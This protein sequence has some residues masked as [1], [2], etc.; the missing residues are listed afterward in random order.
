MHSLIDQL[1]LQQ[2]RAALDT[3]ARDWGMKFVHL[4][5]ILCQFSEVSTHKLL[6]CP[7]RRVSIKSEHICNE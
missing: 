7:H 6:G 5:A 2:D 3:W 4:N 1:L